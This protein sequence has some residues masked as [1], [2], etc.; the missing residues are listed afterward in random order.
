MYVGLFETIGWYPGQESNLYLF[1]RRKLFY[2]LNYRDIG[3][4]DS[5]A[6]AWLQQDQG[7]IVNAVGLLPAKF[8][9]QRSILDPGVDQIDRAVF[10]SLGA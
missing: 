1:L 5:C 10:A 9:R 4:V 8:V 6:A 2:P 7:G 3:A